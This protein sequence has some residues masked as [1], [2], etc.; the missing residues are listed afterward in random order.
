MAKLPASTRQHHADASCTFPQLIGDDGSTKQQ[1]Q[2]GAG[3]RELMKGQYPV[4]Y[5]LLLPCQLWCRAHPGHKLEDDMLAPSMKRVEEQV[6]EL[7]RA[8]KMGKKPK[9]VRHRHAW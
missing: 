8:W 3:I 9:G 1:L 4:K 5:N 7:C 6:L 2:I